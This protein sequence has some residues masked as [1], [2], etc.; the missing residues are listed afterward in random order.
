MPVAARESSIYMAVCI[1]EY[2]RRMGYDVLLLAD[3]ISRWAEA[4]R[5]ISSSL[6]EMPGEEGYPTYLSSRIASY[7]ERAGAVVSGSGKESSLSM[8]LSVSPPGAD[9][10]NLSTRLSYTTVVVFDA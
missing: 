2:Y 8:I 7:V 4:L 3:S 5:E 1:G 10:L 9:F 6:E